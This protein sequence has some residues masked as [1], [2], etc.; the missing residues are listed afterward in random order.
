MIALRKEEKLPKIFWDDPECCESI[1]FSLNDKIEPR[2]LAIERAV[3]FRYAA[4]DVDKYFDNKDK[5]SHPLAVKI[6]QVLSVPDYIKQR[7]TEGA[8]KEMIAAEL[9]DK[10]GNF[11]LTYIKI[12]RELGLDKDIQPNQYDALK[13][14]GK[15]AC[16]KGKTM[17]SPR[18][19]SKKP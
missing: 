19:K 1:S 16:D 4:A 15:R 11:K 18:K 14:R 9:Y 7:K 8:K 5:Q 13:H 17:L 3:T 6:N 12:A 2:R 10:K